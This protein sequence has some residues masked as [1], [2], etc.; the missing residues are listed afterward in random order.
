MTPAEF[1]SRA[2][3]IRWVKWRSDWQAV[4][5]YG[6]ILLYFR[7]VL[8]IDLGEVPQ[9]D[10]ATGFDAARGWT[11]CKPQAGAM[12]WMAWRNG[13]PTH[14][15]ILLTADQVLHAEGN[16]EHPGAVRVSRLRAVQQAYG[17][18]VFYRH[19]RC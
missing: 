13:A 10:I 7:E 16:E 8:G 6:L 15:G 11:P 4:D 3:G 19:D 12:A 1:A 9:T 2:V 14:C 5:C 17:D 18:I